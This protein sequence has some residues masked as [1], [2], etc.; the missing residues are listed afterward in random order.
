MTVRRTSTTL[1]A[2]A[3]VTAVALTGGVT[4]AAA[5]DTENNAGGTTTSS[6][7]S[8]AAAGA[9]EVRVLSAQVSSTADLVRGRGAKK[10]VDSGTGSYRV[11]FGRPVD[12]CVA[13]GSLTD[14]SVGFGS[15]ASSRSPT[16]EAT[17]AG[18]TS[19]PGTRPAP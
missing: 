7:G 11:R 6:R 12:T 4:W 3:V 2:A 16:T 9:G 10:V 17:S 15:W 8:A 5:G 14:D 13:T 19:R 1:A 18:S